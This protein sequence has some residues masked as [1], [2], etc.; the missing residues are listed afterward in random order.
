MLCLYFRVAPFRTFCLVAAVLAS[1][2]L[3]GVSVAAESAVQTYRQALTAWQGGDY[4]TVDRLLSRLISD[5]SVDPRVYYFRGLSRYAVGDQDAAAIDFEA[6][7]RL[8]VKSS[9]GANIPKSLERV[10]GPARQLLEKYRRAARREGDL[11]AGFY[12]SERAQKQLY[13]A[14]RSAYFDGDFASTIELLDPVLQSRST[15]PR[16]YYFHGLALQQLDRSDDAQVDFA[17][18]VALETTP[19]NQIDVDQALERVQG[20]VRQKLEEQ[21]GAALFALRQQAAVERREMIASL[22]ERR[23]NAGPGSGSGA[24]AQSALNAPPAPAATVT[25][26]ATSA[27]T[28][29]AKPAAAPSAATISTAWLAPETEVL[30]HVRVADIWNA[31]LLRSLHNKDEVKASIAEMEAATGLNPSGVESVTIGLTDVG[32]LAATVGPAAAAGPAALAAGQTAA[33]EARQKAI[34]VV[35]TR[36]PFDTAAIDSRPELFEKASHNGK[37]YYSS[38]DPENAPCIYLADL[39]TLVLADE[40][41]LQAAI[42]RGAASQPRPEFSFVDPAKQIAIVFAPADPFALT[43]AIPENGTGSPGLDALAAAVRDQ[44]LAVA[45]GIGVTDNIEVEASL[46]SVDSSAAKQM[47]VAFADV[48]VELK[49]LWDLSKFAAPEP[50]VPFVDSLLRSTR[51]EARNDVFAVSTRISQGQIE[52]LAADLEEMLP[53][54]MMGALM[55]GGPGGLPAGALPPGAV[56]PGTTPKNAPP[57]QADRPAGSLQI[58]ASA[59]MAQFPEFVDGKQIKPVELNLDLVGDDAAKASGFGYIELQAATDNNGTALALSGDGL[60]FGTFGSGVAT[61]DRDDFFVKHPDNGCRVTIRIAPP[62]AAPTAIASA[63]GKLKLFAVEESSEVIVDNVKSLLGQTI[64]NPQ[65]AAAG[66]ELKFT[67]ATENGETTWTIQWV[68]PP[69]NYQQSQQM[70]SGVGQG[71]GTPELIDADG[72][73]VGNFST[74]TSGF[75]SSV[76]VTWSASVDKDNPFPDDVRLRVKLNSKVSVVDVPFDVK[77]VAIAAGE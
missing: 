64:N 67:E 14:A 22:L 66:F 31:P 35:R 53:A 69:G 70:I 56:T 60:P 32:E 38:L 30:I 1:L 27:E 28:S 3:A 48:L 37:P 8:E 23:T 25:T 6:G 76:T 73:A 20:L 68:N 54:L 9:S 10:Q 52:K 16:V 33:L 5:E 63:Q 65:L 13:A 57:P 26:P 51:G 77:D 39:K 24:T 74:A 7:A 72:N 75:G 19:G 44:A 71:I 62:E 49:G 21:R 47:N 50:I 59:Q 46:L 17:R 45:V 29:T 43:A 15:D 36:T 4:A 42:D 11:Q 2:F 58:T 12:R 40:A 55:G 41:P 18:A 61:I 34:I